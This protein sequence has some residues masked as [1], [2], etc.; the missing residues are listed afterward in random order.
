MEVEVAVQV[1]VEHARAPPDVRVVDRGGLA[2]VGEPAVAEVPPEVVVAEVR[3]V[4]LREAVAVEVAGR[5]AHPAGAA[6]AAA[7]LGGGVGEGPV[8]DVPEE[9]VRPEVVHDEQVRIVVVVVV[10]PDGLEPVAGL[11][12]P[13]R[14]RHVRE[15]AVAVVPVERVGGGGVVGHGDV[16]V[17]VVVVVRPGH[18]GTVPAVPRHAGGGGDVRERPV[19]VVPEERVRSP[20]VRG[21]DVEVAVV[22]VVREG[23]AVHLPRHPGAGRGGR[24]GGGAVAVVPVERVLPAVR[25]V[26]VLPSVAVVVA[27]GGAAP[28]VERAEPVVPA[29]E[30]VQRGLVEGVPDG[31]QVLHAGG[32]RHVREDRGPGGGAGTGDEEKRDPGE[33]QAGQDGDEEPGTSED[34][35]TA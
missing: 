22:V 7:A 26:E 8:A 2:H 12:D 10:D 28:H 27:P 1:V 4:E 32:G 35:R 9:H 11:R 21:E 5:P 33:E 34:D 15:G 29:G 13:H 18:A 25:E 16:E 24:V 30:L 14:R 23:G 20:E 6:A 3:H 31:P 19:P 17:A